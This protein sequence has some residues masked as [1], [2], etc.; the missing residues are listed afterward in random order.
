MNKFLLLRVAFVTAL[1]LQFLPRAAFAGETASPIVTLIEVHS[2]ANGD[3]WFEVAQGVGSFCPDDKHF[4]I[5]AEAPNHKLSSALLIS[6]I[7]G[8]VPIRVYF[9]EGC[10]AEGLA[11]VSRVEMK[12]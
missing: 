10:T 4:R 3:L 11:Q 1:S 5:P 8:R 7:A 2:L 9:E 6:A 12:R